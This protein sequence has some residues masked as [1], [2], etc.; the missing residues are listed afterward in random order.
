MFEFYI[1]ANNLDKKR[2]KER[3]KGPT[4]YKKKI[5]LPWRDFNRR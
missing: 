2:K 5:W 1:K 3:E 4:L